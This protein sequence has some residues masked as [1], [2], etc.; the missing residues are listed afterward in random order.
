LADDRHVEAGIFVREIVLDSV[1]PF[2]VKQ[3]KN[4]KDLTATLEPE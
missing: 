1:L 2:L 3:L 4:D